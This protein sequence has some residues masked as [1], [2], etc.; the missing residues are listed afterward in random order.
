MRLRRAAKPVAIIVSKSKCQNCAAALSSATGG[1]V[2]IGY[3]RVSTADQNMHLQQD[4]LEKAGCER[5]FHDTAS[6]A[7]DDRHAVAQRRLQRRRGEHLQFHAGLSVA[8]L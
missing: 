6:G 3:A 2:R 7:K 4:A 1:D 8:V 5:V